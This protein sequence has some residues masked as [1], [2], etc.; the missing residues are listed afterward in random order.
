MNPQPQSAP[1]KNSLT[2]GAMVEVGDW[3]RQNCKD[4]DGLSHKDVAAK[5]ST[6]LNFPITE[7]NINQA[8]TSFKVQWLPAKGQATGRQTSEQANFKMIITGQLNAL[9]EALGETKT[10]GFARL[11]KQFQTQFDEAK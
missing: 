1:K 9:I 7:A 5:A 8:K 4:F 3:L 6:A 11:V 10:P 2:F